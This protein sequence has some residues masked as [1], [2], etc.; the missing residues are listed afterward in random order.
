MKSLLVL[1]MLLALAVPAFAVLPDA[2]LKRASPCCWETLFR[3]GTCG[4]APCGSTRGT[5]LYADDAHLPRVKARLQGSAWKGKDFH[6]DGSFTNRWIGGI[7][8][9]S[10]CT[11]IEPSWLDGQP[12]LVMQYPPDAPV[13]GNVR[14]ELRQIGPGEWIGRSY[15]AATGRA[16]YWFSLREK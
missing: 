11:R 8:A 6:G 4:R 16:K 3:D 12:C 15:D 10:A 7:H 5:V 14:D 1:A 9:I 2:G 13:F